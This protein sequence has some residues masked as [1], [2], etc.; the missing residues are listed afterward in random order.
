MERIDLIEQKLNSINN[1]ID[2]LK[3]ISCNIDYRIGVIETNMNLL[4]DIDYRLSIIEMRM[5][6]L[7]ERTSNLL[8][9]ENQDPKDLQEAM[10]KREAAFACEE[11]KEK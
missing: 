4:N 10:F 3:S 1:V 6:L 5:E 8:I 7:L 9:E 11:K 2:E